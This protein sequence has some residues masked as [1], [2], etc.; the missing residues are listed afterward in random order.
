LVS[1]QFERTE[2][3]AQVVAASNVTPRSFQP[4]NGSWSM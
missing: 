1:L 2:T 3:I 4:K